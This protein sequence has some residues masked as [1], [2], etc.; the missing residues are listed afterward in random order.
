[1]VMTSVSLI[2]TLCDIDV[3]IRLCHE[4]N[5][6]YRDRCIPAYKINIISSSQ[7]NCF[8]LFKPQLISEAYVKI[9]LK[10]IIVGL[11]L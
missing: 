9:R 1:M 3:C 11:S 6:S 4:S 10:V 7:N 5:L 8:K 2:S